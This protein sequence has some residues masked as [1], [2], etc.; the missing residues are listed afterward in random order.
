MRRALV[1][2][3]TSLILW[4]MIAQVNHLL[5]SS[6]IYVF[7]GGLF[8]AYTALTFPLGSGM[9]CSLV[10]GMIC[11]AAEPV[12]FGTFVLLYATAH[13]VVFNLR[14]RIPRDDT[15]ASVLVGLFAN[16]GIFF[17]LCFVQM[18]HAPALAAAWPRILVDLLVSQ[19]C[20]ALI[21]PWFF[22]LQAK[23]LAFLGRP[24]NSLF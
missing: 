10:A 7:V 2:I 17:A 18:F 3:A 13:A 12:S 15:V 11:D 19:I 8:V 20:L 4:A 1:I 14:N 5:S 21:A 9:I 6:H 23:S 22:A 16:L 24:Q